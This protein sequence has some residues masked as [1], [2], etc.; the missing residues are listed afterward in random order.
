MEG[1]EGKCDEG[2]GEVR[3]DERREGKMEEWS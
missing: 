1:K 2:K 3:R